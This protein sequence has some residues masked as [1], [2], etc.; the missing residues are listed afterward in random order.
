MLSHCW[1]NGW[2]ELKFDLVR[3]FTFLNH[4]STIK[5]KSNDIDVI[6]IKRLLTLIRM[7]VFRDGNQISLF[8]IRNSTEFECI[9]HWSTFEM[10]PKSMRT[11][12]G[13]SWISYSTERWKWDRLWELWTTDVIAETISILNTLN[14]IIKLVFVID[15]YPINRAYI[16]IHPLTPFHLGFSHLK[17]NHFK[18]RSEL[19]WKNVLVTKYEFL[20]LEKVWSHLSSCL[21]IGLICVFLIFF[22]FFRNLQFKERKKIQKVTNKLLQLR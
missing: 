20:L 8:F 17:V 21:D 6:Y 11:Y 7:N 18:F 13:S 9:I 1:T 3:S 5:I 12:C 22:F 19:I 15:L 2:F 14:V 4:F 16:I 10:I